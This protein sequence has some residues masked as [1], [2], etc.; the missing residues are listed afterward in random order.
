[1]Q[2]RTKS[3]SG[4]TRGKFC[5]KVRIHNVNTGKIIIA[6]VPVEKVLID[7]VEGEEENDTAMD[8]YWAVVEDGDYEIDGVPGTAA[9]VPLDFSKCVGTLGSVKDGTG[10][11]EVERN[12]QSSSLLPTGNPQDTVVVG[13][14]SYDVSLLDVANFVVH[15]DGRQL[16]LTG[17][18]TSI[19]ILNDEDFWNKVRKI[20]HEAAKLVLREDEISLTK[21]FTSV[22]F[23]FL[24][25]HGY[26]SIRGDLICEDDREE[27]KS[28]NSIT[29]IDF[30]SFVLFCDHPHKAYPGTA[31]NATAAAALIEGTV[32]NEMM[33]NRIETTVA[34]HRKIFR[35]KIITIGH[36]SGRI[37]VSSK[38]EETSRI[39]ELISQDQSTLNDNTA[40]TKQISLQRSVIGRTSR[41][42]A[43]G[44]LYLKAHTVRRLQRNV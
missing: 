20:R 2:F 16:A 7:D 28:S 11:G 30:R 6:E 19:E 42:I 38:I 1:M 29:S 5:Q 4:D 23:P 25:D 36:P 26:Q 9:Y 3:R 40:D 14:H 31:S 12:Q 37:S 24:S 32:V 35:E 33:S 34:K 22:V 18:E 10:G 43:D 21:P 17:K 8:A 15:I 44:R 41:R 13:E 27:L 39:G